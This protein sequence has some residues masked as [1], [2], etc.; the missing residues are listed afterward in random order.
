M[1]VVC[2]VYNVN[3]IITIIIFQTL[4]KDFYDTETSKMIKQGW[5]ENF[6]EVLPAV[7]KVTSMFALILN[8]TI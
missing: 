8:S 6:S 4:E 2:C 1:I 7:L 3:R 5:F